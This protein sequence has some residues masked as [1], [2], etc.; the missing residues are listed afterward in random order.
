VERTLILLKPDAVQR[1]LVGSILSRFEQRGLK[2]VAL[3]LMQVSR[4]LAE[5]HYAVH[6]ERPFFQSLIEYITSGPVVALVL[7][8]P[9]AIQAAR[10]TM[11]AT[12]PAAAAPGTI[13]GDYSL[14]IG[15]NLVHGSDGPDTA[16]TEIGL[17]FGED[18]VNYNR[19][20][21]RW[22]LE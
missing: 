10:N 8:G 22:L 15:R 7:E 17:W 1:Q 12:N 3:K 5:A 4:S 9:G 11:G 18:L 21:D 14:E 19:E 2:I 20:I 13:R 6:K 16:K